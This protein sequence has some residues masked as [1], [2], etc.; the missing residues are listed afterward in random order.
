M[1]SAI[2][3]P[4]VAAEPAD[5]ATRRIELILRQIDSLPTLPAVATRLLALTTADDSHAR[6]V[7]R[8]VSADPALTARILSLCRHADMG[9]RR[10]TLNIDRAVVLLGFNAVR[11]AVLSIQVFQMFP[12]TPAP[13]SGAS[14][15]GSGT[16]GAA[17]AEEGH[18]PV[19]FDRCGFWRH[20]LAVGIAAELIA[21][22][23]PEHRDLVPAEAFVCGL[24]HDLGKLAL[25]HVL[26]KAYQRVVELVEIN[27]GA[28]A[29]YERRILGVDHHTAGKRL[30]EQWQLSHQ[31]QDCI[32]LHGS[33]YDMLPEL[34]HKR[35]V[36]LVSLADLFVRKQHIGFSGNYSFKRG[37][38]ELARC[39]DLDP[40]RVHGIAQPLREQVEQRSRALGL[41]DQP[42]AAL[43]M[44]SI[45][46]A[47]RML[48]RLNTALEVRCRHEAR[49]AKVLDAVTHFHQM[50][51][52]GRSAMDVMSLVAQSAGGLF[53]EGY[54]ALL[55]QGGSGQPWLVV[56]YDVEGRATHQQWVDAPPHF[57]DLAGLD[58]SQP[59]SLNMMGILPWVAD[60]LVEAPDLREIRVL[61]L[62]CGWGV[63][64]LLLH[65]RAHLPQW[66]ELQALSTTW[67][68]AIAAANQH[69][70]ARRLGEQ[71][72]EANRALAETQDRLLQRESMARLGEM[73]AGAAHEMNNPLTIISGRAQLLVR[74]LE[75]GSEKFRA[76]E[77]IVEQSHRL[78][79]LISAL[80]SFADPPKAHRR[81]V[82]L[83]AALDVMI[84]DLRQT[85][86]RQQALTPVYLKMISEAGSVQ[87]D[88]EKVCQA[89]REL[90]LNALQAN[91]RTGV[92]VN[93]KRIDSESELLIQVI[94]DGCGMEQSVLEHAMDPFFSSKPAG[95]QVGMGL[96]RASQLVAAH[97]GRIDLR[98]INGQGTRASIT[99]PL[100]RES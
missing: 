10:D 32:W 99:I 15:A 22:R 3:T 49:Q 95:R 5:A 53:G 21:Q 42:S 60:Y 25:D 27:Q 89:V 90:L 35:M 75:P 36:G 96:T 7:I 91:P 98:S 56:Q 62:T 93:V 81:E 66:R 48:G 78:S 2:Q 12:P 100:D 26:P 59:L 13:A 51:S 40:Q 23:H 84:R 30:A 41:E 52:P 45:Q 72:A 76:A 4:A 34:R 73:A 86:P 20:C 58:A 1:S 39:I 6:E 44:E 61:P 14:G 8:L 85:L 33:T 70:G 46:H 29:E 68:T 31:I 63:A 82:D 67:G 65:D 80:R 43:F 83:G 77:H 18:E 74:G 71:L 97:G 88:G 94:D 55:Y 50:L 57:P 92:T 87:L 24:L 69:D 64:G 38:D 28:I 19:V 47:N 16:G 79:D 54:Y 37:V 11:N 9:V 17:E